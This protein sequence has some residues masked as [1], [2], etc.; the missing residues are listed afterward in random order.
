MSPATASRHRTL[1]RLLESH[2][3]SLQGDLVSLLAELGHSVTQ[4]TVSRDLVALGAVKQPGADGAARYVI[5]DQAKGSGDDRNRALADAV[6][7]F[8]EMITASG[9][10]V[11]LTT[12]PGA[13]HL[14]AS[15]IDLSVME[16]I[17][18]TVAGDDTVL[19]VTDARSGGDRVAEDLERIG[20]GQ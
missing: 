3:I 4:A 6:S 13:A 18:G 12:P 5:P 8:V 2:A 1:R 15:A 11:V 7:G 14:V 9:N 17:V 10:L 19:I 20:V 16:G